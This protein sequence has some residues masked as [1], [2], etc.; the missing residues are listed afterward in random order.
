MKFILTFLLICFTLSSWALSEDAGTTGF[1]FF[2]LAFSPRAAA[3]GYAFAGVAND[4]EAV[5]YNP[6]GLYQ[7]KEKQISA[8]YMSYLEDINCG[9]VIYSHPRSDNAN[10]TFYARFLT[11]EETRTESD[12]QGN[13]LG[14]NGTFGAS[15]LEL[16]AAYAHHFSST[17]NVG[18]TAKFIYESLDSNS[19]LAFACDFGLYHITTNPKL[20]FG[21]VLRNVGIQLS[22]FT[23]S[24]YDEHLPVTADLGFGYRANSKLLLAADIYRPLNSDFYGRFGIEYTFHQMLQLRLGYKTDATDWKKGADGDALAGFS[25]GFALN[26]QKYILNYAFLSYGDLGL[27]NQISLTYNF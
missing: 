5:F 2:K 12:E 17:L 19:A 1:A 10:T 8:V 21:L 7:L 9:A 23:S 16:G 11:T 13:Y 14:T 26:W 18:A 20:H 22:S 15:D 6:A 24:N 25:G 4:P 3:L 27:V